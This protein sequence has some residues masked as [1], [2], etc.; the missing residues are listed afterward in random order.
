MK[1]FEDIINMYILNTCCRDESRCSSKA[2]CV[3]QD[4]RSLALDFHSLALDVQSFP[5]EIQ[6][7]LAAVQPADEAVQHGDCCCSLS[8]L[9]LQLLRG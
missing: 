4:V 1:L 7:L 8:R 6:R 2:N 9:G 5:V 3:A